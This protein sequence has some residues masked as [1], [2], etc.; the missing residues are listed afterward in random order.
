MAARENDKIDVDSRPT[1]VNKGKLDKLLEAQAAQRLNKQLTPEQEEQFSLLIYKVYTLLKEEKPVIMEKVEIDKSELPPIPKDGKMVPVNV[2]ITTMMP[3]NFQQHLE[4]AD[5]CFTRSINTVSSF[6]VF[7]AAFVF[8]CYVW[9]YLSASLAILCALTH[10]HV[11]F[12]L[13]ACCQ[14]PCR[15]CLRRPLAKI[16][17]SCSSSGCGGN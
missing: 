1:N 11:D 3:K 10:Q 17:R 7:C 13:H 2:S 15:M 8:A 9:I 14:L 16:W 4:F 5:K 6:H 12:V